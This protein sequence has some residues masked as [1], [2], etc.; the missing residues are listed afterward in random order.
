MSKPAKETLGPKITAQYR[1]NGGR[2]LELSDGGVVLA[3]QISPRRSDDN[4]GEWHVEVRLGTGGGPSIIDGWGA[5]PEEARREAEA[6]WIASSPRLQPLD[7]VG[8]TTALRA[9]HAV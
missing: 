8:I 1:S 4:P 2:V 3:V 9:V 5:T 7:W 6:R